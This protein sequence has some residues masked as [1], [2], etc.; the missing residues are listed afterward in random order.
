VRALGIV[1]ACIVV[2]IGGAIAWWKVSYPTYTYRY[3]MTVEVIVD[4]AVRSGSSVREVR[5]D[6]Q[7]QFGSAPPQVSRVRGEAVFIDLGDGR[8]LIALLASG[9]TAKDVN[10]SYNVVPAAFGLTFDDRDLAKLSSLRGVRPLSRWPTFVTLADPNDP[11]TARVVTDDFEQVFG[12]GVHPRSV[13]VEP[14]DAPITWR[15]E[16]KMPETIRRLREEARKLQVM[17]PNDPYKPHLGH[18]IARGY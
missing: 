8:N 11:K 16:E 9:P 3:R 10:Y 14:T 15:I 18:F 13:V 7:P 5:I 4:G 1:A 17:M 12:P 6:K 2:L